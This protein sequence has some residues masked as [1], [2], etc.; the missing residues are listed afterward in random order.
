[1]IFLF[2]INMLPIMGVLPICYGRWRMVHFN[3]PNW[4][5][6]ETC[7]GEKGVARR[8][9]DKIIGMANFFFK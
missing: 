1:M 9:P 8:K 3:I 6:A 2:S 4:L 5:T 7:V